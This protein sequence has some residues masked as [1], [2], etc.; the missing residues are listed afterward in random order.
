[1]IKVTYDGE[2]DAKYVSIKKGKVHETKIIED[3]LFFDLNQQG[4]ILGIEILDVSKNDVTIYSLDD[5]VLHVGFSGN[6]SNGERFEQDF[7][8]TSEYTN[9]EAVLA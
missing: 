8:V 6:V 4:Q 2:V 3:W 1:M 7:K 9:A 5:E